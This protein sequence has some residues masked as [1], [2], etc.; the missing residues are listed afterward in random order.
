MDKE[1]AMLA[2]TTCW[3][4][5]KVWLGWLILHCSASRLYVKHCSGEDIWTI[6][7]S[8]LTSQT[9]PCKGLLWSINASSEA[10]KYMWIIGGGWLVT[11][12]TNTLKYKK[13]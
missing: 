11:K 13:D 4:I 8:P 2:M 7:W 6:L 12:L 1:R 10:L 9:P 3:S 5:S